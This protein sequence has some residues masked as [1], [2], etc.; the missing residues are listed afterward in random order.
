MRD[1]EVALREA[2]SGVLAN[3]CSLEDL[4]QLAEWVLGP[5][6][7]DSLGANVG[8]AS[9]A[10]LRACEERGSLSALIDS[11]SVL[12]K[13]LPTAITK[14]RLG[15][16]DFLG[17]EAGVDLGAFSLL[18]QLGE[19]ALGRWYEGRYAGDDV[20]VR[21]VR[22]SLS[23]NTQSVTRFLAASRSGGSVAGGFVAEVQAAE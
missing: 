16:D 1:N 19:D 14:S 9:A 13:S 12:G 7:A 10:L 11:L 15:W 21:V 23:S 22:R 3:D 6:S 8:S 20:I 5:N 4:S 2:I 18:Q 17:V